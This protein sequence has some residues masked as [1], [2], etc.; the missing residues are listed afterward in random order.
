MALDSVVNVNSLFTLALFLGLTWYPADFDPTIALIGDDATCTAGSS[1]VENLV[2]CH[3]YS[4]SCFLFSSLVALALKQGIS[5]KVDKE[6][7]IVFDEGF[8]SLVSVNALALR[9]GILFSSFGSVVGCGFLMWALVD[10]VQIKLGTLACGSLYTL[11]A[12][13][14]LVILVPMALAIFLFLVLYAFTR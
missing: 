14:P 13:A 2:T 10:L 3:V 8:S 4:F 7:S 12:V 5:I 9:L 6:E 1:I 11:A